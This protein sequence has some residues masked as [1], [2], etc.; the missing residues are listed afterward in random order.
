MMRNRDVNESNQTQVIVNS[1]SACLSKEKIKLEFELES[2]S[3]DE[4]SIL[5]SE[6]EDE[7]S[8]HNGNS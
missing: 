3:Y 2:S 8:G 6:L 7:K 1:I 4:I 5:A